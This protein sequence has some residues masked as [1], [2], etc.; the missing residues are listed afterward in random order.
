MGCVAPPPKRYGAQE[1][2]IAFIARMSLVDGTRP[3][4]DE[5]IRTNRP[6]FVEATPKVFAKRWRDRRMM[7]KDWNW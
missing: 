4:N 1:V 6:P 7:S 2:R 5:G 3:A